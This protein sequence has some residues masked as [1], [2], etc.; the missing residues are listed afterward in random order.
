MGELPAVVET[1]SM[2][3]VVA[4]TVVGR[5]H[6]ES[7]D[8]APLGGYRSSLTSLSKAGC[9]TAW[10]NEHCPPRLWKFLDGLR[11]HGTTPLNDGTG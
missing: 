8:S 1:I 5:V 3:P 10:C 7:D 4:D 9:S 2:R 11:L 6:L